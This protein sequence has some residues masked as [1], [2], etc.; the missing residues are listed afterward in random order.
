MSKV[1]LGVGLVFAGVV[2][3]SI[4]ILAGV[5]YVIVSVAKWAWGG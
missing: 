3:G 4:A 1:D 2:G 5:V